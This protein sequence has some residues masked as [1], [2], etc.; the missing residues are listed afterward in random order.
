VADLPRL[1]YTR[2]VLAESMRLYPPAWV[3]TRLSVEPFEASG[4]SIPAGSPILASQWVNH[5]QARFFPEP[6]AFRPERWT[7]EM[8]AQLPRF[9]YFPFGGGPRLCIGEGFAWMESKLLVAS[10]AQRWQLRVP[11]EHPVDLQPMVT[12]RP[13]GGMP[14]RV[15]RRTPRTALNAS[16]RA[17]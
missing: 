12:L 1:T 11:P 6:L 8:E 16:D 9:A 4:Y 7:P 17:G 14:A 13:R 3:L 15:E 10:I 2:Q 5:H